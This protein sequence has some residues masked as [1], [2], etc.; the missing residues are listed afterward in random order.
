MPD[1]AVVV[2]IAGGQLMIQTLDFFTPICDD[3]YLYG[4]IAAANSLSDVYAMGG[5]PFTAMNICCFPV[6]TAG[7]DLLTEILR[8]GAERVAASGAIL[9]GGHTVVDPEP[10]FGLSVTGFV[11]EHHLATKDGAR[12]GQ[13]LVL[14]KPLG[15]GILTTAVKR[16]LLQEKDISEALHGMR[17]LNETGCQLMNQAGVH[18]ATDITGYGLLGHCWEMARPSERDKGLRFVIEAHRLPAYPGAL[19]M[20]ER[21][22]FPGGSKANRSWLESLGAVSWHDDVPESLRGL[23]TDA[24]TSGGLLMAWP[25]ERPVPEQLWTIGRVEER[26]EAGQ[27]ALEILP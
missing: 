17:T 2:R 10:K 22:V 12:P 18:T 5:K 26:T 21:D 15:T 3:P 14:S 8:G 4:Q 20:A 9:A 19:E 1:D 16:G 6:E 11:E 23:A 27:T 7:L 25:A 13:L 24:Q